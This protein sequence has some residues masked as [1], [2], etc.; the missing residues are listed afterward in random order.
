MEG[1][2][3]GGQ[4]GRGPRE[5]DKD[6]SRDLIWLKNGDGSSGDT[7]FNLHNHSSGA[8]RKTST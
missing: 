2:G 3:G 8:E 1:E 7:F 6:A 5:K 4:E